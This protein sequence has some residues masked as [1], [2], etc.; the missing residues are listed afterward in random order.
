MF[1]RKSK[2]FNINKEGKIFEVKK[3]IIRYD[4]N[5]TNFLSGE[6]TKIYYEK[7]RKK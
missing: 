3:N 2:A 5:P 4:E 6:D 1:Q 7:R